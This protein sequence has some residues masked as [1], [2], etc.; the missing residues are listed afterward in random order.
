M[1]VRSLKH[2]LSI[3][4]ET[5]GPY[6]INRG[7]RLSTNALSSKDLLPLRCIALPQACTLNTTDQVDCWF[8]SDPLLQPAMTSIPKARWQKP[9]TLATR[10]VTIQQE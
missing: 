1:S 2:T 4:T 7:L 8:E 3:W 9:E 10:R 5:T 6:R